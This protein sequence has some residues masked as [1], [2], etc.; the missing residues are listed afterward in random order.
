MSEYLNW[1]DTNSEENILVQM[2]H[3]TQMNRKD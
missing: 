2:K 3:S 1:P